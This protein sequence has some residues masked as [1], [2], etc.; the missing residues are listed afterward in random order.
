MGAGFENS[1]FQRG[2]FRFGIASF[3]NINFD[4]GETKLKYHENWKYIHHTSREWKAAQPL[5]TLPLPKAQFR[6]PI[7]ITIA[8]EAKLGWPLCHYLFWTFPKCFRLEVTRQSW[9][10]LLI[11]NFRIT[12]QYHIPTLPTVSLPT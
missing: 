12:V 6:W 5:F 9:K 4:W 2:G 8:D 1:N 11:T 10:V 7:P 3:I